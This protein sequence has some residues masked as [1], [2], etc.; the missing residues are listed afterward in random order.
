MPQRRNLAEELG[1]DVLARDEELDGLD[2]GVA[3][4]LDEIFA[5]DREEAALLAMLARREKLPDEPELLVLT[6]L[7]QAAA[8]DSDSSAAFARSATTANAAGSDTA[9]SA[10]DLRSS[11][12]PARRTPAMNRL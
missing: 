6:R 5:L 7:D 2:G 3:G 12:M 8:V 11:S 1:K 10:S 4:G 9:M